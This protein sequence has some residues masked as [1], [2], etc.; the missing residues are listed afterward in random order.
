MTGVDIGLLVGLMLALA[1]SIGNRRAWGWLFA[2][3]ASYAVST[4]Y[5]RSGLPYPS[6]IAG[7]CDAAICLAV[8]FFARLKW[9]MW[10]WRLFQVSV[11][12]N[13]IY[14]AGSLNVIPS[15]SHNDYSVI[16]EI[17]NWLALAFIGGTGF[18]QLIGASDVTASRG[19]AGRIR[20]LVG[21]LSR[22]RKD[23]PFTAS[24]KAPR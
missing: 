6:F 8:Y 5:W 19:F 24:S 14:L 4:L 2:A 22:S 13:I 18:V 20:G 16:L 7:L 10:V 3:A 23:T 9:E 17:I 11:G 21:S 12:V 15:L 1:I